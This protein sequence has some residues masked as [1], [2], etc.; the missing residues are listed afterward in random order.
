MASTIDALNGLGRLEPVDA[1]L[2]ANARSLAAA[3]D[4]DPTNA[5]LRRE[6]RAMIEMLFE[7][8]KG[9]D[10]G[11]T[12]ALEALHAAIRDSADAGA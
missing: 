2:V 3:V 1:A 11:F 5:Q 6:Y 12:A 8:G 4:A 9:T 7:V 10:G